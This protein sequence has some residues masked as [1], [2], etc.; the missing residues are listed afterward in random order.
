MSAWLTFA[1]AAQLA[2]CSSGSHGGGGDQPAPQLNLEGN[3]GAA[4]ANGCAVIY[5]FKA[6]STYEVAVACPDAATRT[7][8]LEETLG[9]HRIVGKQIEFKADAGSCAGAGAGSSQT[10]EASVVSDRLT[11]TSPQ[12]VM[13]LGRMGDPAEMITRAGYV[14]Q[15]GCFIDGDLKQFQP[16]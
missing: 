7:I 8:R 12:N 15:R 6:S 5:R 16:S 14:I 13:E 11:L 1:L 3:F 4:A 9:T 10:A 2:A